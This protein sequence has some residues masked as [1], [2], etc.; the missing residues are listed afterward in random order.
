MKPILFLAPY[1]EMVRLAKEVLSHYDDVEVRLG[2][3]EEAARIALEAEKKGVEAF[4]SRG[5]TAMVIQHAGLATPVVEIPVSPYD[6]LNAIHKAKQ[7]GRNIAVMGFNNIIG[8]VEDLGPML[9]VN[10]LTFP[11]NREEETESR[12][13]EVLKAR[14]D[15]LIDETGRVST[16]NMAA[17]KITGLCSREI[18]GHSIADV[19]P[20]IRLMEVLSQQKSELGHL[21]TLGNITILENRIPIIVRGRAVGAVATFQDVTK[22]QE[23]EQK[24]RSTL[25]AKGHVARYSFRDILGR[26]K[27][28]LEAK[29]KAARFAK[30]D[31]TLMITGESGTGKEMFAQ[32]IHVASLRNKG[33][34]V[35][36]N[37]AAI[38]DNLLESE[39]F[40]YE[41][42]AFTG[43]RRE[44]KL[45]LFTLAHEG[46][47]FLDEIAEIPVD[48]QARLL[49]VLQEREVRPLG[50]D[51]V[52]PIN[53][54]VLAAT[55][56]NLRDEVN[57]GRFRADLYYRLSILNLRIPAL[58]ERKADIGL[59]SDHFLNK[60]TLKLLKNLSFPKGALVKLQNYNWPGNIRELDNVMES[61][62]VLFDST[63]MTEDV[64]KVLDERETQISQDVT[65]REMQEKR[66]AETLEKCGGNKTL[67]ATSLGISRTQLWRYL[68]RKNV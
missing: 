9:D 59:L 43:A 4:V 68:K 55:N 21:Q 53:V 45:G 5:G 12:L 64:L 18:L 66:I 6:M 56:K 28:L 61:L 63:L 39:L 47:I 50:S 19:I 67:A 46:T 24:I 8:G 15:V 38:P 37:C 14:I 22:I 42:G 62:A 11:I 10:L 51:K 58:R 3:L 34:F 65:L 26:S 32:S 16:F 2:L 33:P 17:E 29:E 44:G 48:L 41:G 31:S 1:P 52:L 27:G 25:L 36:V 35:A 23:Y 60:A 40:G 49:R 54:R 57:A 20:N 13:I 30:V 7:Y